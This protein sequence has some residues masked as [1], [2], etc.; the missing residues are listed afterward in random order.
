MGRFQG[1]YTGAE[2]AEDNTRSSE[3]EFFAKRRQNPENG[4]VSTRQLRVW[5]CDFDKCS[6]LTDYSNYIKKYGNTDN[7]YIEQAKT[8]VDDFTFKGCSSVEDYQRYLSSFPSGRHASNAKDIIRRKQ[9]HTSISSSNSNPSTSSITGD[10]VW[11][12]IKRAIGIV[13]ILLAIGA[14]YLW[15]IDEVKWSVVAPFC[16]F[17][18][19]PVCKWAFDE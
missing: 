4:H 6:T 12:F 11:T 7:P 14:I 5:Q 10:E 1:F 17:I 19:A 18:V 2:I 3:S 8:K 16:C 9:S 15:I 13:F